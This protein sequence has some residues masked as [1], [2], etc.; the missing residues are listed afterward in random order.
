MTLEATV[1]SGLVARRSGRFDINVPGGTKFPV[2]KQ[3]VVRQAPGPYTGKGHRVDECEMDLLSVVG[4]ISDS[5]TLRCYW[6]S[7]TRVRG[8]YKFQILFGA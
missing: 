5:V 4:T 7:D 2:G 1:V 3:V 8:T 6:H